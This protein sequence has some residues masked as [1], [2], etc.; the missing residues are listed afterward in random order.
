MALFLEG[1]DRKHE[2]NRNRGNGA[3][4]WISGS[5]VRSEAR[6]RSGHLPHR[7]SLVSR[8]DSLVESEGASS[9]EMEQTMSSSILPHVAA[10][11]V[12]QAHYSALPGSQ[13][14]RSECEK[15]QRL[16]D[17]LLAERE[18]LRSELEKARLHTFCKDYQPQSMEMVYSQVDRETTLEQII[19]E[20]E[21]ATEKKG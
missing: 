20:L 11:A 16:C 10:S 4:L 15:W 3:G 12:F 8:L 1:D 21:Q 13:D 18:R 17:Q 9:N 19:G 14:P 2:I 6:R 5:A 7:F